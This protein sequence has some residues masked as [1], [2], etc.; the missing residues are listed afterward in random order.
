MCETRGLAPSALFS[1]ATQ[2]T[3]PS[4]RP[5]PPLPMVDGLPDLISL[6]TPE[7]EWQQLLAVWDTV[8]SYHKV[9]QLLDEH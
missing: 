7:E 6:Y 3:P 4:H 2:P 9:L 8:R 5:E 1:L